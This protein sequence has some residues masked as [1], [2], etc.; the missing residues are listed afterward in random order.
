MNE[1]REQYMCSEE[2]ESVGAGVM[3]DFVEGRG[4]FRVWT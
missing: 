3:G 1:P 2:D 4:E